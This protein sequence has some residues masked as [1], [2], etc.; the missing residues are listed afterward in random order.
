[1]VHY[2]ANPLPYGYDALEPYMDKTTMQAHHDI[3]GRYADGLNDTLA[4]MSGQA[5]PQ[6]ASEILAE[7]G[8]VPENLRDAFAF[9]AG[10]YDNH[11]LFWE[12][13][14]PARYDGPGGPLADSI[15]VYFGGPGRL[16]DIFSQKA[17]GLEGS[18]WCWLV[19]EPGFRRLEVVTTQNEDSPRTSGMVPLLGCDLWEHAYY[20][21]YQNRRADYVGAW[22]NVV[23]WD[24]AG[25]R[26]EQ[27]SP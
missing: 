5:H 3:H 1:M 19:Y 6:H 27:I 24:A 21:G 23:N 17:S 15:E 9:Y 2:E 16:K 12:G 25:A 13:I 8:S 18:G 10:G 26:F 22:W 11:Q 7:M 4:R 20:L 14:G